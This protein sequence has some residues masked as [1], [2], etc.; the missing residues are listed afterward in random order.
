MN[1]RT[2]S[3]GRIFGIPVGLDYSW[4]LIFAL[5][6]WTMAVGAGGDGL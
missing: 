3:L 5:L 6:T 1:R 4:F 2:I